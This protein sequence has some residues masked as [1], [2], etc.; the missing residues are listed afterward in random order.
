[1]PPLPLCRLPGVLN[2][3]NGSLP[4]CVSFS[5]LLAFIVVHFERLIRSPMAILLFFLAM[6]G[7]ADLPRLDARFRPLFFLNSPPLPHNNWIRRNPEAFG[8]AVP[9]LF[10]LRHQSSSFFL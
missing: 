2:E 4:S 5:K 6:S 7:D 8:P 3:I 1:M 10:D 9:S